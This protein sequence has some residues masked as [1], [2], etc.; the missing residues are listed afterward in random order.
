MIPYYIVVDVNTREVLEG[1]PT[2]T[3]ISNG[4]GE[5]YYKDGIWYMKDLMRGYS[6]DSYRDV[7]VIRNPESLE[8]ERRLFG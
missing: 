7:R 6:A 1:L 3:L 8:Q 4:R 2:P 5:A